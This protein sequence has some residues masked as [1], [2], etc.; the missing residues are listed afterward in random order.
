LKFRDY[1]KKCSSNLIAQ[2]KTKY[3]RIKRM[4]SVIRVFKLLSLEVSLNTARLRFTT[5]YKSK[6]YADV[7][8][9]FGIGFDLFYDDLI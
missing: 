8:S 5:Y 7:R 3:P 1:S 6:T 4:P 9:R 2:K